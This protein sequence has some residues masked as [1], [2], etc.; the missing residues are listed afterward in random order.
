MKTMGKKGDDLGNRIKNN[1][2][3][4]TKHLLPRRTYTVIRI[5]GKSFHTYTRGF[6]KPF[7]ADLI[8]VMNN[9]A[10]A[11]CNQIQGAKLAY[12]QSDEI[13]IVMTDFD[14]QQT[15]AWFNGN[16]QKITS[17]SASIA[18]AAFNNGMYLNENKLLNMD[19]VAY[20][21]SRVF[22]I[23]EAIE[24]KNYLIWRQ[25]DATRNSIQM[26]ARSLASHK[27]CNNL[28][29]AQLQELIFQRGQNWN[30]YPNGQK[31]G[32]IIVKEQYE[33]QVPGGASVTR[34]RWV[35]TAAPI[36]SKNG[37]IFP[38]KGYGFLHQILPG[39]RSESEQEM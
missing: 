12:V 23:P 33:K 20:F 9:T 3:S 24:V 31:R 6:D 2:E 7:D 21:D 8:E 28:D 10:I 27:E 39:L 18:T 25:Q 13:S 34:N 5:D 11:L 1:Y 22:T 15:D 30:N 16:I 17:V 19:K 26:V 29:T 4:R 35:A 36:F 37:P 38:S 32:R 14:S